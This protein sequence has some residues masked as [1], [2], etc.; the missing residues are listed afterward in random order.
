MIKSIWDK[1]PS[2]LKNKYL[3]TGLVFLVIM[4]FLDKNNILQQRKLQKELQGLKEEQKFYREQY[5]KDSATL[6]ELR[7][8]SLK[9]EKLG[10][11]KYMMKKDSEDVFLIVRKPVPIKK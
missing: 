3:L 1:I 9:L 5:L 8:D 2:I 11:E 7:N 4:L 10:R 6:H